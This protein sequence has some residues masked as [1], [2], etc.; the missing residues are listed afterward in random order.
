MCQMI[1]VLA[2]YLRLRRYLHLQKGVKICFKIEIEN[3]YQSLMKLKP[4][5]CIMVYGLSVPFVPKMCT[6]AMAV[7]LL[8]PFGLSM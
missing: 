3:S 2:N 1:T 4:M 5:A 8:V 6:S 7:L